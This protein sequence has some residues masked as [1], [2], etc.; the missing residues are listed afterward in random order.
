MDP[1]RN[2]PK[3]TTRDDVSFVRPPSDLLVFEGDGLDATGDGGSLE[4]YTVP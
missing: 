3:T 2:L 1:N 4:S